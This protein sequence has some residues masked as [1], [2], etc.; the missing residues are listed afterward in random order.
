MGYISY[1]SPYPSRKVAIIS[2]YRVLYLTTANSIALIT[3]SRS[4]NLY[5]FTYSCPFQPV[6][7][8][9]NGVINTYWFL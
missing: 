4:R 6:L 8:G 5:Y 9:L 2:L 7:Q 3:G 1:I